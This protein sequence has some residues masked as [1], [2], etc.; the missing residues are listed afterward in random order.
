MSLILSKKTLINSE[1]K[2]KNSFSA[3]RDGIIRG[4]VAEKNGV[5][6]CIGE[7]FIWTDLPKAM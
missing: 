7:W 1:K 3:D 5:K 4:T 6:L 2:K